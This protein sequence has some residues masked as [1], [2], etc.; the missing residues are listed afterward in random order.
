MVD[1]NLLDQKILDEVRASI[2]CES[3]D[4]CGNLASVVLRGEC[5]RCSGRTTHFKMVCDRCW[6]S[7]ELKVSTCTCGHVGVI[8]DFWRVV[9]RL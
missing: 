4:R 5:L 9:F 1:Q 8:L 6:E 2:P 3:P 7:R